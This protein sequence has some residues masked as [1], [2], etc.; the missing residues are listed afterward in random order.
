MSKVFA[1]TQGYVGNADGPEWELVKGAV[2]DSNDPVVLAAPSLF[3]PVAES[4]DARVASLERQ[5]KD[6]LAALGE[7][8]EPKEPAK[9][10]AKKTSAAAPADGKELKGD[11]A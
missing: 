10:A 1:T 3:A 5:V 7:K 6:L 8:S 4:T 11:V 9:T 2:Y